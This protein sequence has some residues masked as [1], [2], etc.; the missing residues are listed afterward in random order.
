[1][2]TSAFGLGPRDWCHWILA[3]CVIESF[4]QNLNL[5][6]IHV[7]CSDDPMMI[8]LTAIYIVLDPSPDLGNMDAAWA[9]LA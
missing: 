3:A 1:L 5:L 8:K 7:C 4:R 2:P 6:L 9:T